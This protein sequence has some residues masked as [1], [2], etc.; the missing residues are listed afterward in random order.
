VV[1]AYVLAYI[2]LADTTIN[3]QRGSVQ[4]LLGRDL[5]GDDFPSISKLGSAIYCSNEY[6]KECR[7]V[8]TS[9]GA[10]SVYYE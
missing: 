8:T 5:V 3:G 6:A 9:H 2:A 1:Y 7:M 10:I 4:C